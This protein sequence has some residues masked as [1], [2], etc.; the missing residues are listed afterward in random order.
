MRK[1]QQQELKVCREEQQYAQNLAVAK[2]VAILLVVMVPMIMMVVTIMA[3]NTDN[4][5]AL[6]DPC[7]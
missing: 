4:E 3:K 5:N 6:D 1:L 7:I 2:R